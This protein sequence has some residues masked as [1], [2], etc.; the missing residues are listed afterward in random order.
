MEVNTPEARHQLPVSLEDSD[1]TDLLHLGPGRGRRV[2]CLIGWEEKNKVH[3]HVLTAAIRVPTKRKLRYN[4]GS[5]IIEARR[6]GKLAD[7][8]KVKTVREVT[9]SP[10]Q[11]D[12]GQT[13]TKIISLSLGRV[14]K[15][16]LSHLVSGISIS[17]GHVKT[18][19]GSG[20]P[21][22]HLKLFQATAKTER[23]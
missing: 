3:M 11:E 6:L 18:Y 13:P 23:W 4:Q 5:V 16:T 17:Q 22:D 2:V 21:E 7:I 14:R 1:K 12:T 8:Q 15:E 10:N 19:D 9:G 20:D